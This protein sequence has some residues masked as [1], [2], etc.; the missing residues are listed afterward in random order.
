M[1][2]RPRAREKSPA[3]PCRCRP[4]NPLS[5]LSEKKEKLDCPR[6]GERMT[7]PT[8]NIRESPSKIFLRRRPFRP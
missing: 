8:R 5:W 1:D 2:V 7:A 4:G 3:I 6:R